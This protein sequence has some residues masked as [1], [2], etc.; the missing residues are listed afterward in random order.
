MQK[1]KF[2]GFLVG[3]GQ[4]TIDI[5]KTGAISSLKVPRTKKEIRSFLGFTSFYRT[6]IPNFSELVAPITD[7]LKNSLPD[8]AELTQEH[9]D[10]FNRVKQI[11]FARPVLRAPDFQ[12]TFVVLTDSSYYA[13]AG[14]LAQRD[15]N[16]KLEPVA[17]VSKKFSDTEQRYSVGEKETLAIVFTLQKFKF[18]LLS[19]VFTLYTDHKGLCVLNNGDFKNDRIARWSLILQNFNFEIVYLKGS[20]NIVADYLSRYLEYTSIDEG[21]DKG[22]KSS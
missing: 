4:K 1:I 15:D 9:I 22:S 14:V 11:L 2:L 5:E 10:V 17:F 16:N 18:Y 6:F 3:S 19:K 20:E 8:L 7:L 21:T 13:A 12:K